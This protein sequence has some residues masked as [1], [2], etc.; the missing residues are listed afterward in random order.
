MIRV[1]VECPYTHRQIPYLRDEACCDPHAYDLVNCPEC[2]T[3]H[4]INKL[5]GK[6]LSQPS[7][8]TS[9]HRILFCCASLDWS[10]TA[11]L[12]AFLSVS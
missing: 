10:P 12:I 4:L 7:S 6:R 9:W 3:V 8:W 1:L 2:G 5:T 11:R